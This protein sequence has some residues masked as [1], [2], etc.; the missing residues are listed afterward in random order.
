[1]I[2]CFQS[3]YSQ[4]NTEKLFLKNFHLKEGLSQVVVTN[5]VED[6]TGFL[7]ASTF[8]GLNR[9]DGNKF[10]VFRHNP[11][12]SNSIFSSKIHRLFADENNH[13][14]LIT[15]DGFCVYNTQ[16]N[17]VEYI[18]DFQNEKIGW[19]CKAQEKDFLWVFIL[20]KGLMKFNS[21]TLKAEN[22]YKLTT[23]LQNDIINLHNIEQN[24][25]IVLSNG[26]VIKFDTE[27]RHFNVYKNP[28][29]EIFNS[30]DLDKF[31]NL[32]LGS[33]S[34]DM[35]E[36]DTRKMEH[37]ISNLCSMNNRLISVNNVVYDKK[38]DLLIISTY[39]QGLFIYSYTDNKLTQYRKNAQDLPI[40]SDYLL[41]VFIDKNGLIFIGYD[42]SGIDRLDPHIKKFTPIVK[43]NESTFYSTKFI[44]KIVEG[45]NGNIY[46]GTAGSGLVKYNI[47]KNEIEFKNIDNFKNISEKYIIELLRNDNELWLGYNGSGIGIYD[48]H[49]LIHKKNISVG[50]G[51]NQLSNGIIWSMLKDGN[52][53]WIGTRENGLNKYDTHTQIITQYSANT[54]PIFANNG[55]RCLYK[56]Q[57]DL[58]IGTE[59]GLYILHT[60]TNQ[61]KPCFP[62]SKN[63]SSYKSIKSIYEDYK[64]R[65]WLGTDGAGIVIL[66]KKYELI[67]SFSTNDVLVN[68]VV[69]G[70]L[71]QS[72]TNLWISTNA[73]IS[74]IIW[75]EDVIM[76]NK[77]PI[78]RNYDETNGLQSNEFNTGA[79]LKLRNGD[80]AFGG[81]MGLNIFDP[82][83]IENTPIKAKV[84][85]NELKIFENPYHGEYDI[86]S[87]QEI[88]LK[89]FENAISFSFS[90]LGITVPEKIKYKYKLEGYD[91]DWITSNERTYVSYTNLASGDYIFKVKATNNDGIWNNDYTQLKIHIATPFYKTWWFI[92]IS[93]VSISMLIFY[94]LKSR[95]KQLKEKERIKL[96]Y[97]KE[98]A[99]VEMKALRAQI[100]PHFLFNSLN[101]IN[102][103]IL[104]NDT[105]NASRYLIKFSQLVRNILNHS[106]S[107]YISLDEELNTVQLYMVI[108][109]M[110]FS[111]QF[112]YDINIDEDVN[113][114]NIRIPSLLLQPYVE[115]AIWHGLLH[116]EGEKNIQIKIKN[117]DEE[118][119]RIEINDNGVGRKKAEEM[120]NSNQRKSFGMQINENRIRLM[121]HGN[122]NFS[123]ID[124]QDLYDKNGMPSGTCIRIT[125]PQKITIEK[126]K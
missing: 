54:Y 56:T 97:T 94:I 99:N 27:Q 82:K 63:H 76:K 29:S 81:L 93:L 40:S 98:L 35:K 58:L 59:K 83:K 110:R 77:N 80:L 107:N 92:L 87:M 51:I 44:R 42:G 67:K 30:S 48:I 60:K 46:I 72:D 106:S 28:N 88:L 11:I 10:K 53:I 50:T 91:K 8:D 121:N 1:M 24:V 9:F 108:E 21:K 119:I 49:T 33:L 86:Q 36:F 116:K 23:P 62:I 75:N 19:L 69:Y 84:Y 52:N 25:F 103:F 6:H 114:S 43:D 112:S 71:P 115:N 68:N 2:V 39:G 95:E 90:T 102:N 61:I 113:T 118:Y 32:I 31:N 17:K 120:N 5:L 125:I 15:N 78:I 104:K 47:T 13:L 65:L 64:G 123:S 79:Y 34:N 117:I 14:Y 4:F 41:C 20:G 74:N 7:W 3:A 96:D 101:S 55:L 38:N 57:D 126:F 22:T 109:G 111:N 12:D 70:I 85:I 18:K 122:T 16:K 89:P 105:K 45:D 26:D 37:K 73:G 66:N 124:V 100:N